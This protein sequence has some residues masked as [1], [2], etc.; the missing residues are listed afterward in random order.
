MN[1]HT[2]I[3]IC[4]WVITRGT[5]HRNINSFSAEEFL[6]KLKH[7]FSNNVPYLCRVSLFVINKCNF[8][9]QQFSFKII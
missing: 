3:L 6:I 7:Y 4:L 2:G 9:I 1:E 8:K 5:I